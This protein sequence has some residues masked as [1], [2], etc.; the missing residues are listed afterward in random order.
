MAGENLFHDIANRTDGD[1]YIGIVGPVRTGKSTFIKRFMESSVIPNIENIYRKERARD[2]LPQSGSGRTVMTVEPKFVPEEAVSIKIDGGA[3]VSVRLV[4]C[5]G[6]MVEGV[7][8]ATADGEERMVTTPWFDH[9]VTMAE[10][11]EVG[12][13]KVIG[14]H[15]TIGLVITTDGT[16]TDLDRE[17][18]RPAEA[19]VINELREIGKPF[20]VVVNSADPTGS[21]AVSTCREIY[22]DYGV[23]AVAVDCLTLDSTEVERLL[24]EVLYEFPLDEV[25]VFL[26]KW[27]ESLPADNEISRSIITALTAV[28]REMSKLADV[29]REM[30]K[31][32]DCSVVSR[33]SIDAITPATGAATVTVELP[34]ALFYTTVAEI[35]GFEIRDDGDLVSLLAR[36]RS[37]CAEYSR[38]ESA[39]AEVRETGYGI[40]LPTID[41]MTLEQPKL[42]REGGHYG[43]S[44]RAS[45]PSIHLIR[46]DIEAEVS[47]I[48]GTEKQS[49]ELV[50]SLL[51]EFREDPEK[52]WQTDIFGKS[53]HELVG[54]GLASKLRHMPDDAREK[55]RTT[56]ERIINEGSGGLICI[57][58]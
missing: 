53:M 30:P 3:E 55:L 54:D 18:Y 38:L 31:L 23:T 44:L 2:E 9:P 1:I 34:R 27:V 32:A 16:I 22:D 15:S 11:A 5:V 41:E 26:P 8:G 25:G 57:I 17:V 14:E 39:L 35:S 49:E 12:T 7:S 52:L 19:R 24:G 43:V 56:L 47:P 29:R 51:S 45:A 21:A 10:A 46:A 6:Y 40:V 20:L 4:D 33:V 36:M 48:V 58:L 50:E 28:G 37:V 13:R 42:L